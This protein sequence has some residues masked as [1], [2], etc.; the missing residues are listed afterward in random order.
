MRL[1]GRACSARLTSVDR[2]RWRA[3]L[4]PGRAIARRAAGPRRRGDPRARLPA[5]RELT[6]VVLD[7]RRG[8]PAPRR[9]LRRPQPHRPPQRPADGRGRQLPGPVPGL[10]DVRARGADDRLQPRGRRGD[11]RRPPRRS[12]QRGRQPALSRIPGFTIPTGWARAGSSTATRTTSPNR[13]AYHQAL[14]EWILRY[15]ERTGRRQDEIVAFKRL[16]GRGRQPA[17]RRA[18]AHATCAGTR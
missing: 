7:R 16:Q 3:L 11:R 8:Q 10:V 9:E 17:A 12:V 4:T 6:V 5:A 13:G 2:A 14:Q 15:P 1:R 18:A